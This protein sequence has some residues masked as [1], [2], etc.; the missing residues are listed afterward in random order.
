LKERIMKDV[1]KTV[2]A[3]TAISVLTVALAGCGSSSSTAS[4]T[5][6]AVQAETQAATEEAKD[7]P[8]DQ[9]VL[10]ASHPFN[11]THPWQLGLEYLGDLLE[12]RT[13]GRYTVE[14]HPA[15]SLSGGSNR[16][17]V[18]MTGTGALQLFI[19]SGLSYQGFNEKYAV[20]ALPFM[21]PDRETGFKVMEQSELAQEA[22]HWLEPNG[23]TSFSVVENGMRFL[24]NSKRPVTK[25]EDLKG[26]KI[27]IPESQV[28]VSAF[29]LW[30][31]DPTI[32]NMAE[33]YTAIQQG[34]VDGQENPVAAID[35][36]KLYEVCPYIT[37]WTYCWDPAWIMWNK[38]LIDGLSEEDREIFIQSSKDAADY[39]NKLI[40]ENDEA[41][42]KSFEEYG[43][44][45][46]VLTQEQQQAFKDIVEPVYDEYREILGADLVD[47]IIDAVEKAKA[48]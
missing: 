18:E 44:Q 24:T 1:F 6:A 39:I 14:A 30:G 46:D 29:K 45:V 38:A 42:L 32:L 19:H 47:G 13:N 4:T 7:A 17:I 43:C 10:L 36:N 9:I 3:M 35:S 27:R 25:P 37:S 5:A 41:L 2:A 20:F 33:V 34:T 12:E 40:A 31:A 11:G 28:L 16:S 26:L 8:A 23:I 22:M 48:N 21:F 15:A